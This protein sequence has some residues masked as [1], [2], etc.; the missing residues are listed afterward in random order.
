M[1]CGTLTLDLWATTTSSQH[2]YISTS[3][4]ILQPSKVDNL[5]YLIVLKCL[6]LCTWPF[7]HVSCATYTVCGPLNGSFTGLNSHSLITGGGWRLENWGVIF[8][9]ASM[10]LYSLQHICSPDSCLQE[11]WMASREKLETME[12]TYLSHH[13]LPEWQT[14]D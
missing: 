9:S 10:F 1:T 6:V 5:E 11:H 14:F 8:A 12:H 3:L 13:H 2:E 4:T 7:K